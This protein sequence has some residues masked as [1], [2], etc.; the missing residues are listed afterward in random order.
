MAEKIIMFCRHYVLLIVLLPYRTLQFFHHKLSFQVSRASNLDAAEGIENHVPI[1]PKLPSSFI[2]D[3]EIQSEFAHHAP[4]VARMNNGSF[5]CCPA[6]VISALQQW[7]LKLLSQPDHF[8]FNELE[9]RILESRYKIKDLINAEDVDEVSIVDN[10]STAVAIVLQQ[11]A[12][13][14]AEGKFNKGD[15]VIMFHCAYGAVKNSIKAYF[16]RAGG[17]VIEVQFN[18]P[19]NSNEEIIS[20]FSKALEREKGN[21]RRVRLAVI[22]HV[23][24]MPSVIMPVKQLVKICREEGIEQV[25]IDAAHGV[26]CVDVDMQEIG[27]DFYAS[28]LYKWFFCPPAAAFLYCRKSATYS[29]LQLHHP[30]VSHRDYTPYLVLPSAMEFVKRFEGGVEGI[31]KMNHDAVVEMGKMLAEA[32]GTNLGCPPDMCASM[33]M[34]GLPSCLGISSDDD[35]TKLWAHLR[36]KFGVEVRIHYQAPKDGEVVLTMGY[37][38]ICHQIY[39]KVDD[40][41]KLRDAINQL[42]HDG[43]TCALEFN[44]A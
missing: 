22:D 28:T 30:V 34:V 43:F 14:F 17:Y 37:V 1:E 40:Y 42:V 26:G 9:N 18:F 13:A 36:K 10:I 25:F 6:S 32:W 8:Y 20:E 19:L 7:Q 3:S 44:E 12:W 5:G 23:T 38:R 33:I 31:R 41:Y 29:D 21:G 39:N 16:S 35:A 27:A 11:A 24:C 15:A 2:T 4:G